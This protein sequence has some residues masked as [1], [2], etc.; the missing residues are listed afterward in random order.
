MFKNVMVKC[1]SAVVG[2]AVLAGTVFG[3]VA[4][5]AGTTTATAPDFTPL[6][7]MVDFSTVV[8]AVL[9]IATL[10][11]GVYVA[12]RGAKTILSMIRG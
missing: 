12:I 6:T 9:A 10:L 11:A 2:T 8:T 5:A 1:K 4:Q 7:S 3:A